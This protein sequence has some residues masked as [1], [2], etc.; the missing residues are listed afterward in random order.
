MGKEEH[1]LEIMVAWGFSS[2]VTHLDLRI[3]IMV[4]YMLPKN[5]TGGKIPVWISLSKTKFKWS[6]KKGEMCQILDQMPTKA[7]LMEPQ[8]MEKVQSAQFQI[9]LT[10]FYSVPYLPAKSL[11][12]CL[13]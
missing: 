12:G 9:A 3:A 1:K 5:F 6:G 11:R 8:N 13:P 7:F 10:F 4:Q 2:L